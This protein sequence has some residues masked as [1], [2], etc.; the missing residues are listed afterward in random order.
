MVNDTAAETKGGTDA[1]TTKELL[2][3]AMDLTRAM[4]R[5]TAIGVGKGLST[6][7][8]ELEKFGKQLNHPDR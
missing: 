3:A 5:G 7:G 6:L 1:S 8:D 4:V 2:D